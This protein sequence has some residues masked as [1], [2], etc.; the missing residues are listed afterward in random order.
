[1]STHPHGQNTM[2]GSSLDKAQ[3]RPSSPMSDTDAP[4]SAFRP[5][6]E[7]T[8]VLHM[9][10]PHR[11]VSCPDCKAKTWHAAGHEM[12]PCANCKGPLS[13]EDAD[14]FS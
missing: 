11:K 1:M 9:S 13:E 12:P 10:V 8:G 14:D 7:S 5:F 4:G 3:Q 6:F 2:P